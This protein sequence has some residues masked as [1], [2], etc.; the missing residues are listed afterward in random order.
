MAAGAYTRVTQRMKL[1]PCCWGHSGCWGV[2]P[3]RAGAGCYAQYAEAVVAAGA[4]VTEIEVVAPQLGTQW[5]LG[6]VLELSGL[7]GVNLMM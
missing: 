2:R 1:S 7:R 5:P 3:S 4:C 6:Q